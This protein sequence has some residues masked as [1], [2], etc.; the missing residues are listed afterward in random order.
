MIKNRV[1]D[2]LSVRCL[3]GPCIPFVTGRETE[4]PL[5][6][7]QEQEQSTL[8]HDGAGSGRSWVS[9]PGDQD[10]KSVCCC[11]REKGMGNGDYH[12]LNLALNFSQPVFTLTF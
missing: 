11:S 2:F 12:G 4:I 7:K 8:S 10:H 6:L 9:R 1:Q 3:P 5:F